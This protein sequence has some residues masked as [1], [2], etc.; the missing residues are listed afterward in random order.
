MV[1]CKWLNVENIVCRK[2]S[3]RTGVRRHKNVG[4]CIFKSRF[5]REIKS[6]KHSPILTTWGIE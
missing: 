2:V 3:T 1:C 4:K 6:L 5:E